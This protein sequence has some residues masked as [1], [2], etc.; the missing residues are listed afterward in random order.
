VRFD[1]LNGKHAFMKVLLM[2]FHRPNHS[3]VDEQMLMSIE[4]VFIQPI[5]AS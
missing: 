3:H 2:D 4:V 1:Q 5:I